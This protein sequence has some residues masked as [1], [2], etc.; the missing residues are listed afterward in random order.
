MGLVCGGGKRLKN[1]KRE[2]C[3]CWN[4]A[5]ACRVFRYLMICVYGSLTRENH[6]FDGVE[7]RMPGS[8]RKK[9]RVCEA[10]SISV[11]RDGRL[12]S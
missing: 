4:G 2:D 9:K 10:I 5:D 11:R 1:D 12:K 6:C 3:L 7:S 8:E